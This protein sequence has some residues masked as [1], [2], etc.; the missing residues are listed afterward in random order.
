M[1][2]IRVSTLIEAPIDRCFDLA[3]SMDLHVQ[4]T[5]RTRERAVAGVTTGLIGPGDEVTFDAIHFGVRQRLTSRIVAYDRPHHFRDS[6]IRSAFRSM[7]HDHWF[8]QESPTATR[9]TDVVSFAAPLGPLGWLAERLLLGWYLRRFIQQR[10]C[11]M[12][13]VAESEEWRTYLQR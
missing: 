8:E 12:K 2:T 7:D 5:G 9:M 4:S 13:Q 11:V 3:R 10:A 6:V 1:Y